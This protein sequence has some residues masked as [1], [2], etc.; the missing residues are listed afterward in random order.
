MA[1]E[2]HTNAENS[3]EDENTPAMQNGVSHNE[4]D[5]GTNGVENI[6]T[7]VQEC[8]KEFAD[9]D[10]TMDQLD[11]WMNK[12]EDQNDDLFGRI[13]ELLESNR[14][15]KKELQEQNQEGQQKTESEQKPEPTDQ[16]D[17]KS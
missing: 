17:S 11:T 2:K 3:R 14:Q 5:I 13:E 10:K 1:E 4:D 16:G 15:I 9:L 6:D 12:L 7:I 8:S